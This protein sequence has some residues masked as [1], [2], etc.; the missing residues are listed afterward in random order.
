M[1]I[2]TVG[3]QVFGEFLAQSLGGKVE[4]WRHGGK[5][6]KVAQEGDSKGSAGKGLHGK[7]NFAKR[8]MGGTWPIT[9]SC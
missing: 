7:K 3:S 1:L 4:R 5:A 6:Q 2:Q 9:G 8:E